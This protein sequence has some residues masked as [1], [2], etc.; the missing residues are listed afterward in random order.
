MS[1]LKELVRAIVMAHA[2]DPWPDVA[3]D[4]TDKIRALL[5]EQGNPEKPF[6][7]QIVSTEDAILR[8]G[9]GVNGTIDIG[10]E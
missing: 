10:M 5:N 3:A 9:V 1:N 2:F 6:V 4:I 7:V 8:V